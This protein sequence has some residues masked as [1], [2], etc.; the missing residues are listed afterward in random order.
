MSTTVIDELVT[1]LGVDIKSGTQPTVEKF[2][3]FLGGV[4]K[5]A[6][7]SSVALI[8]F[9]GAM[10]GA[11]AAVFDFTM[12][13]AKTTGDMQKTHD[14]FGINTKD[15]QQMRY[16]A[17]AAGA[18]A[19][20]LQK[21]LEHLVQTESNPMPE[22][23]NHTL[24]RMG[25]SVRDA[26]GHL[27]DAKT[28]FMDIAD[29]M[30]HPRSLTGDLVTSPTDIAN[31][32]TG[33]L[34]ALGI[35]LD[36]LRLMKQTRAE[37]EANMAKA[38]VRSEEEIARADKFN[39]SLGTL[40]LKLDDLKARVGDKLLPFNEELVKDL[41]ESFE[42]LWKNIVKV[43]D[44]L[45]KL[46]GPFDDIL[47]QMKNADLIVN[48][49]A[50]GMFTL[51]IATIAATWEWILLAGAILGV[52]AAYEK[53]STVKPK[54][55]KELLAENKDSVVKHEK[56]SVKK[57]EAVDAEWAKNHPKINKAEKAVEK[58]FGWDKMT[59]WEFVTGVKGFKKEDL[60]ETEF[61]RKVFPKET[62]SQEELISEWEKNNPGEKVMNP[63]GDFLNW[64]FGSGLDLG[65]SGTNSK[66]AEGASQ[67]QEQRQE[68]GN[69]FKGFGLEEAP[70]ITIPAAPVAPVPVSYNTQQKS[71]TTTIHIEQHIQ[72][73][74][75]RLIADESAR[76]INSLLQ[77]LAPGGYVEVFS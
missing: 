15:L 3:S 69:Y 33:W 20:N 72:G 25:I 17:V 31:A 40:I 75:A 71:N 5:N 37:I 60:T 63:I 49:L 27:K 55:S 68:K 70:N 24:V 28:M 21:S 42:K 39:R 1:I 12:H 61:F 53:W 56:E 62:K 9:A 54:T 64:I 65:K 46:R 22:N 77:T 32:Q 23:F 8:G 44:A 43:N 11:V 41:P 29:Y 10:A 67:G 58:A 45:V 26:N 36:Q 52:I 66:K 19:D 13:Q 51:A 38:P 16:A 18:D 34:N 4:M 47:P 35:P 57:Q 2:S 7:F 59:P 48:A 74:D 14:I 73:N 30:K 50:A 76:K 6:E